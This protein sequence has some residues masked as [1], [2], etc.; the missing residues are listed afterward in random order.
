[1]RARARA[2]APSTH[3][4]TDDA[5]APAPSSP[6]LPARARTGAPQEQEGEQPH[7]RQFSGGVFRPC[8]IREN[9]AVAA[10]SI[11]RA[12]GGFGFDGGRTRFFFTTSNELHRVGSSRAAPGGPPGAVPHGAPPSAPRT[13]GVRRVALAQRRA[14]RTA[15]DHSTVS[16]SAAYLPAAPRGARRLPPAAARGLS[17]PRRSLSRPPPAAPLRVAPAGGRRPRSWCSSVGPVS[18]NR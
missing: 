10:L 6:P 14:G 18:A 8:R 4:P 11:E 16:S 3:P 12:R 9:A 15:G 13:P 7:H 5:R 17:L 1:M 2:P